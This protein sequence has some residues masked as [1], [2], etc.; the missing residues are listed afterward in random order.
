MPHLTGCPIIPTST[1]KIVAVVNGFESGPPMVVDTQTKP[2][3]DEWWGDAVRMFTGANWTAPQGVS[4]FDDV[5]AA[6]LTF[7]IPGAVNATHVSVMDIHPNRADIGGT[8][9]HPNK[10]VSIDDVF[11]FIKA[12]QGDQFPG[13]ALDGYTDPKR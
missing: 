2:G 8:S 1:Y 4:T 5:N 6:L 9:V 10:L 3:D 12:F 11:S 7:K 13:F